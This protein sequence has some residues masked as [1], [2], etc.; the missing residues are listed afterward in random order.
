MQCTGAT[1]G[2]QCKLIVRSAHSLEFQSQSPI[3]VCEEKLI[4]WKRPKR[5]SCSSLIR[6]RYCCRR[7]FD[8]QLTAPSEPSDNL[9]GHSYMKFLIHS[10]SSDLHHWAYSQ[11]HIYHDAHKRHLSF[12]G[13]FVMW[14]RTKWVQEICRR[15]FGAA[16][17]WYVLAF[18]RWA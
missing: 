16:L 7:Q 17:S 6:L 4:R 2:T 15:G 1:G 9:V 13:V 3:G 18:T 10:H 8:W 5:D 12:S 11:W 14:T